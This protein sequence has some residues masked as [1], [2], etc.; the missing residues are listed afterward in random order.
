MYAFPWTGR[1][2]LL[3][4]CSTALRS[5]ASFDPAAAGGTRPRDV[6]RRLFPRKV[7]FPTIRELPDGRLMMSSLADRLP[8][9]AGD[10][11]ICPF[12]DHP[13]LVPYRAPVLPIAAVAASP[14]AR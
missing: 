7:G 8:R 9:A 5:P 2:P 12:A 14:R 4:G 10:Q 13:R 1:L 3:R 11:S 6:F